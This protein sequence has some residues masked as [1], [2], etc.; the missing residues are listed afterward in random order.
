MNSRAEAVLKAV[1]Q[2]APIWNFNQ[3]DGREPRCYYCGKERDLTSEELHKPDCPWLVGRQIVTG[4][5]V[6]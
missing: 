4:E 3:R 6:P 1:L 5:R 2:R